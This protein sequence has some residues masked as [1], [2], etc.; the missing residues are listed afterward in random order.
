MA[1]PV[2]EDKTEPLALK[3]AALIWL[4]A[5]QQALHPGKAPVSKLTARI[6]GDVLIPGDVWEKASWHSPVLGSDTNT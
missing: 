3:P 1:T 5:M 6:G 2:L 4:E